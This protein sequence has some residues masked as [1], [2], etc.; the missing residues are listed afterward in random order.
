MNYLNKLRY[1]Y[2]NWEFVLNTF[3]GDGYKVYQVMPFD[4]I[5]VTAGAPLY[6]KLWW[7]RIKIEVG[8]YSIGRRC[9]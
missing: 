1:Y 6:H 2:P 5:I 7:R 3:F 8:W 9:K 4:S